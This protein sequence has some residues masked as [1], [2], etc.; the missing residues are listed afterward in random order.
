MYNED[1]RAVLRY[2]VTEIHHIAASEEDL[3]HL[4]GQMSTLLQGIAMLKHLDF[5]A[6]EIAGIQQIEG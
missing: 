3:N 5:Q 1:L 6:V 4:T 2:I